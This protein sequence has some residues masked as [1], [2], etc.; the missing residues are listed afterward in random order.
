MFDSFSVEKVAIKDLIKR[1]EERKMGSKGTI[2]KLINESKD[3]V[4]DKSG[5]IVYADSF[6]VPLQRL[7]NELL[8]LV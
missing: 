5:K 4:V 6:T 1:S 3:F 8:K 7:E 2:R